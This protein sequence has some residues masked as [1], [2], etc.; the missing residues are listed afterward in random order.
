MWKDFQKSKPTI[1]EL[2][3][4]GFDDACFIREGAVRAMQFAGQLCNS[5]LLL[6]VDVV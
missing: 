2:R 3:L 4:Q 5:T 1:E 6:K